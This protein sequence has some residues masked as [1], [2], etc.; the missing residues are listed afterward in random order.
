MFIE[1][2]SNGKRLLVADVS[3]HRST[4]AVQDTITVEHF[5]RLSISLCDKLHDDNFD[6][7]L[8]NHTQYKNNIYNILYRSLIQQCHGVWLLDD[9]WEW[10]LHVLLSYYDMT[11]TVSSQN[12][13]TDFVVNSNQTEGSRLVVEEAQHLLAGKKIRDQTKSQDIQE[14]FN[15]QEARTFLAKG[16]FSFNTRSIKKLY[17]IVTKDLLAENG[18]K[19]PRWFKKRDNIVG[20]SSTAP[21]AQ[22]IE[23]MEELLQWY[24]T[25]KR[26][27]DPLQLAFD[28][29]FRFECIHPFQDGNGRVGR[30]LLNKILIA[31]GYLPMIIFAENRK[32]HFQAFEKWRHDMRKRYRFMMDQYEKSLKQIDIPFLTI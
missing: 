3:G 16:W 21:A 15:T 25:H 13:I 4:V 2:R 19:Y 7:H 17:H 1:Q 8:Y 12:I 14:F 29:Y 31:Q 30:L 26:I 18:K 10:L 6:Q 20:N 28:F 9:E 22:V 24:Q 32:W 5:K 23:K 11:A 27:M